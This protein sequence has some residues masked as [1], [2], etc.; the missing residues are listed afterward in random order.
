MTFDLRM[1]S[2]ML[3]HLSRAKS[4][5]TWDLVSEES[6]WS[7]QGWCLPSDPRRRS[8]SLPGSPPEKNMFQG[9]LDQPWHWPWRSQVLPSLT[10]TKEFVATFIV[11][12]LLYLEKEGDVWSW[13][14]ETWENAC[15]RLK[16]YNF[17]L[18]SSFFFSWKLTA[19][20]KP[21]TSFWTKELMIIIRSSCFD[22][23]RYW[24]VLIKAL[25][26]L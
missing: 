12:T 22:L 10:E 19:L 23:V 2:S 18:F 24:K 17:D 1:Q 25:K 4:F 16:W 11:L 6:R 3:L 9:S 20:S 5:L 13:W 26:T 15:W 8:S 7:S 21:R 14:Q